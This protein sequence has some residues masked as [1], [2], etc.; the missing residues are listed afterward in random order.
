MIF[1][2]E[3]NIKHIGSG[4]SRGNFYRIFTGGIFTP[5]LPLLCSGVRFSTRGNPRESLGFGMGAKRH[6]SQRVDISWKS[7]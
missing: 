7:L 1:P 5:F 4:M 3:F 6:E 2:F